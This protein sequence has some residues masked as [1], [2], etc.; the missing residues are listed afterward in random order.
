[1]PFF[2]EAIAKDPNFAI[3]YAKLGVVSGNLNMGDEA[4]GARKEG[5]GAARQGQRIRAAVHRL[6]LCL[7]RAAGQE[8]VARGARAADRVVSARLCGAQQPG[9]LLQRRRR[10]RRVAQELPGR[11][12]DRAG[13]TRSHF[14]LRL[15][16]DATRTA[17]RGVRGGRSRA[18]NSSRSQPGHQ[19][20]GDGSRPGQSEVRPN[21]NRP[22]ASWRRRCPSRWPNPG[23]RRGSGS[24]RVSARC[25]T[26]RSRRCAARIWPR[27]PA[28]WRRRAA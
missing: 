3:A 1:M 24:S 20:L 9:C 2:R 26:R 5:V 22:R 21:G 23:W 25:R 12:R 10:A 8:Q 28:C 19:P 15:R 11:V 27:T 17:R 7:A 16:A 18:G 6:E 4:A 14:Q 13:R